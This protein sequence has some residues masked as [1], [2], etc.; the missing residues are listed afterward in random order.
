MLEAYL[1]ESEEFAELLHYSNIIYNILPFVMKSYEQSSRSKRLS[2]KLSAIAIVAAGYG[3]DINT[4]TAYDFLDDMDFN[5][6]GKVICPEIER[7][8]PMLN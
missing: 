1:T 8:L 2:R 6:Y 4:D 3:G 7:M 5:R